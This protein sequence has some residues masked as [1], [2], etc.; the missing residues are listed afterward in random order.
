MERPLALNWRLEPKLQR[1]EIL[2]FGPRLLSSRE[3]LSCP[4]TID[5]DIL[6]FLLKCISDLIQHQR[7]FKFTPRQRKD[8]V[9]ICRP[10]E[11]K[12]R[13]LADN[14]QREK[15]V[16]IIR[17]SSQRGGG[18]FTTLLI[19]ALMPIISTIIEKITKRK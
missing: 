3:K 9:N 1:K 6:Y 17:S 15:H 19:S 4:K 12:L 2:K 16:K 10:Y 8:I 13:R 18:V 11:K 7:Y 14:E 5:T